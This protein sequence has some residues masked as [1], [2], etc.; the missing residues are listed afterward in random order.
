MPKPIKVPAGRT[1]DEPS[2][3]AR[4]KEVAEK[5]AAAGGA[6]GI[7]QRAVVDFAAWRG[8]SGEVPILLDKASVDSRESKDTNLGNARIGAKGSWMRLLCATGQPLYVWV[9]VFDSLSEKSPL[10]RDFVV[11]VMSGYRY[12]YAPATV[13]AILKR[14][15]PDAG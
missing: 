15:Y 5:Y 10:R 3:K 2:W 14:G 6:R 8:P 4:L 9:P 12:A 13:M 1:H 11:Q 7:Y